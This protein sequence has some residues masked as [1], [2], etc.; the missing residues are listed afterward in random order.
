MRKLL[1]SSVLLTKIED[2]KH[3]T[4]AQRERVVKDGLGD[5]EDSVRVAAGKVVEAWF[6]SIVSEGAGDGTV[7]G[8]IVGFLQ[9][10]EIVEF[11]AGTAAD[12]LQSLFVTRKRV[13]DGIVFNGLC[14]NV[15]H[16]WTK[17][18]TMGAD[19][20]WNEL[21]AES[22]LLARIFVDHCLSRKDEPNLDAA[23][24]PVV[25]A[26]A[27]HIQEVYNAFLEL[28]DENKMFEVAAG[29]DVNEEERDRVEE[30]MAQAAFVLCELLKVAVHLDYAD[31][32]GRR[33]LSVVV[34]ESIF[35]FFCTSSSSR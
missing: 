10:F 14:S 35:D 2:P 17:C 27:F 26:F 33:K 23:S 16:M 22:A 18:L 34:R 32:T 11:G 8:D 30:E 15:F 1:Y 25:T 13:L 9:L 28:A 6:E 19:S 20:F 12:A 21:T 5:R 29:E 24:L 3:L 4:I 7:V 31:E